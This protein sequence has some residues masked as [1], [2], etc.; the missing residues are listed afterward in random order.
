MEDFDSMINRVGHQAKREY[1]RDKQKMRLGNV[2]CRG[3]RK[4]AKRKQRG[5]G[6]TD[7]AKMI[8]HGAKGNY[9]KAFNN[10]LNVSSNMWNAG[11]KG[12]RAANY[13]NRKWTGLKTKYHPIELMGLD[14]A[15]KLEQ[16]AQ[17]HPTALKV[18]AVSA[19]AAPAVALAVR[20]VKKKRKEKQQG[21]SLWSGSP[22]IHGYQRF[23]RPG[24]KLR[25]IHNVPSQRGGQPPFHVGRKTI[26]RTLEV[27]P[28]RE[29][30]I[31]NFGEGIIYDLP[32]K[33]SIGLK[34]LAAMGG[35]T[36]ALGGTG[37]ILNKIR[38]RKRTR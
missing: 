4:N 38:K 1:Q 2:H 32:K 17:R 8:Y 12:I 25:H 18:G 26:P 27:N 16:I 20:H 22:N 35:L 10:G 30:T 7:A 28:F 24:C 23:C 21:G 9:A 31:S 6:L 37:L 5:K 33:S 29:K 13:V 11:L 15:L 14:N 34:H 3:V 19:I 36:A